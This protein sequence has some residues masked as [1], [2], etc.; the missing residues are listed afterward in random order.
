MSE[1]TR[2]NPLFLQNSKRLTVSQ[3][4]ELLL[5]VVWCSESW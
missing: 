3:T 4:L 5:W 1:Q 2:R